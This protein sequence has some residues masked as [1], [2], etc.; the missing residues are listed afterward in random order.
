MCM[1]VCVSCVCVFC[2]FFVCLCARGCVV[3]CCQSKSAPVLEPGSEPEP[4]SKSEPNVDVVDQIDD[5]Q[6]SQPHTSDILTV[7]QDQRV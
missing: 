5:V 4:E 6:F 1:C 7:V 3:V 2:V